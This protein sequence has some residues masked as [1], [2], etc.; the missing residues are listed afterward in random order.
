MGFHP[1]LELLVQ[2][3]DGVCGPGA[4]PLAR[5]QAREGEQV[6]AGLLQ[7]VG[8]GPVPQPPFAQEGLPALLNVFGR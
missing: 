6:V 8:N 7:A 4:L 1:S 2:S 3:F 5:R